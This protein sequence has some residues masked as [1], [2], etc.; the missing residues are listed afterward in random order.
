MALEKPTVT[1][2]KFR[3][4]HLITARWPRLSSKAK[5]AVYVTTPAEYDFWSREV[6]SF[7]A[8]YFREVDKFRDTGMASLFDES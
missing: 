7:H 4:G 3:D 8:E 6:H 1:I 2:E 5:H